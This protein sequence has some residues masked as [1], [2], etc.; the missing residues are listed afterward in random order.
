MHATDLLSNAAGSW[1][2]D[3]SLWMKSDEPDA[4]SPSTATV[5][6]ELRGR[7][8]LLRYTWRFG[9]DDHEGLALLGADD[10]GI[11]Q[12][13]WTE[14]FGSAGTLLHQTGD[15]A[16]EAKALAHYGPPDAPWGWRTEFEM[17]SN[18]ELLMLAYIIIPGRGEKLSVRAAWKRA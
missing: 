17:P 6:S 3:Y 11:F 16:G 5:T 14:T 2:G 7:T 8:L 15:P 12:F 18:D 1:V 4:H 10:E 9:E 13:A